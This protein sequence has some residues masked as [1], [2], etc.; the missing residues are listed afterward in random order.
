MREAANGRSNAIISCVTKSE[1]C[2]WDDEKAKWEVWKSLSDAVGTGL[3]EAM[4]DAE[5]L[6]EATVGTR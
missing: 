5:I 4:S 3:L 1:F 2:D 6:S